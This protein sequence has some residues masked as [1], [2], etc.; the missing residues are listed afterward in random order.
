MSRTALIFGG[1][2]V[3]L[4]ERLTKRLAQLDEPFVVAADAGAETALRLGF[5]PDVVVGDFD[6]IDPA[7]LGQ[8][9]DITVESYPRDKNAT[10]GQLAIERALS[11]EADELVLVGFLGGP[12]LDQELANVL[13]LTT[14]SVA[15]TL[16]DGSNECRLVR[17]G[18][19]WAWSA[20]P[21]EIVSLLP[22]G[23]DA[24]GVRTHGLRWPLD[25][26]TLIGGQTRG[27]SNEPV[28]AQVGVSLASGCLLVTR[29]F[30]EP[31]L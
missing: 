31:R 9:Q 7:V 2:P 15:T 13:L 26:D 30:P 20:E 3:V 27:V 10:D 8:L 28:Q 22:L 19:T 12:R 16:V 17:A 21:G 29:H 4:A 11:A 1:A 23:G 6:S 24:D 18:E 25:N 5:V 14:L